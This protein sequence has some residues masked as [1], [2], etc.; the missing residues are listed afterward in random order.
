MA[1]YTWPRLGFCVLALS[2]Y[3]VLM[4]ELHRSDALERCSNHADGFTALLPSA[5]LHLNMC[6]WRRTCTSASARKRA[7]L[8]PFLR[9]ASWVHADAAPSTVR[10]VPVIIGQ[11]A[12]K[13]NTMVAAISSARPMRPTGNDAFCLACQ[14]GHLVV[15]RSTIGVS[16]VEG[17]TALTCSAEGG[18]L[19]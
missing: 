11:S 7:R 4:C 10:H 9:S 8:H 12:D 19:T 3:F 17:H 13:R 6:E 1:C 14:S 18:L 5:L 15:K 2:I 16:V